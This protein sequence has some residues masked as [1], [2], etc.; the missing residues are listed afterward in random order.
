VFQTLE[1]VDFRAALHPQNIDKLIQEK[2]LFIAHTYFSV[3]MA[4]HT[5]R[6][7]K[8]LDTIDEIVA[9][10]FEYLSKKIQNGEVWNPTLKELVD[11]L[12][13]FEATVLDLDAEG[14][15]VVAHSAGIPNRPIS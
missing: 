13:T 14:K 11:F 7:F 2:G 15:I 10:N 1:M 6:L 12:S 9:A 3:P 5:G 4:Y 8:T